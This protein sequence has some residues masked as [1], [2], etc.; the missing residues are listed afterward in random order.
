MGMISSVEFSLI[1]A[2]GSA[3]E[4]LG[5]WNFSHIS[6]QLVF[7]KPIFMCSRSYVTRVFRT[8]IPVQKIH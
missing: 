3:A 5:R 1:E 4:E 8:I 7:Q 6:E 2:E